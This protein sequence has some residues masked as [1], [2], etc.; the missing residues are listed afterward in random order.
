MKSY[1]A[2]ACAAMVACAWLSV[3]NP[4]QARFLQTDS[5]GYKD[6][7]NMYA[8]VGNDPTDKTD[9]SGTQVDSTGYPAVNP[10]GTIVGQGPTD[11]GPQKPTFQSSYHGA[12]DQPLGDGG[13][14]AVVTV[15]T[16]PIGGDLKLGAEAADAALGGSEASAAAA[17]ATLSPSDA[18]VVVRGGQSE[19]PAAGTKFSGSAGPTV[20]D[21]AKGVPHGTIRTTTAGDIRANGGA[22]ESAPEATR[23]GAM[24]D[25]H[26]N[27]TTGENHTFGTAQP[28]PVPKSDRVQ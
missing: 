2:I 18:S 11:G 8:Y 12:P 21:A 17:K 19:I 22:V 23:S 4:A 27:I 5:V 15:I 7:P 24:N 13:E 25:R 9:A 1:K 28:N 20:E 26:V 3:A 16:A 6:D 14:S 10:D